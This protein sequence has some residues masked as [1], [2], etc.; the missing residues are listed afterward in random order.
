MAFFDLMREDRRLV[1]LRLLAD[2]PEYTANQYVLHAAL[3]AAG[4]RVS[5]DLVRSD[6]A[7]LEEQGLSINQT[8]G[9]VILSTAT[10]RG[11]DAARGRVVVPGVKRPEPG[12]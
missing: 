3:E 5:H 9:G 10:A 6:L 11:V 8:P 7:W 12:L 4:H 1:L 2:A